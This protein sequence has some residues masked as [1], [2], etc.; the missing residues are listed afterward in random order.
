MA[1]H[2]DGQVTSYPDKKT[3]N[4]MLNYSGVEP[5][6]YFNFVY[7]NLGIFVVNTRPHSMVLLIFFV[8]LS[9]WN[10]EDL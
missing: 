3:E 8:F 4:R 2:R 9:P 5:P 6:R 1:A 7:N 10:R